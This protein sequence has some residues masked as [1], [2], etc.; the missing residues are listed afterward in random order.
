MKNIFKAA[1]TYGA[2]LFTGTIAIKGGGDLYNKYAKNP[3]ER[4][5][6][7]NKVKNMFRIKRKNP[8]SE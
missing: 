6:F 8:D 3:E 5:K 2:M 7:K 1:I 4:I